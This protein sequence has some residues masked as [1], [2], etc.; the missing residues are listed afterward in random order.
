MD[1]EAET[2]VGN[3]AVEALETASNFQMGGS[4]FDTDTHSGWTTLVDA[5]LP[6]LVLV[7][8]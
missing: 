1:G 6:H 3:V 4:T 7:L 2:L 8:K 5:G